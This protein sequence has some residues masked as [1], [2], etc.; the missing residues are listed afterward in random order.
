MKVLIVSQYFW[1][2]EFR[3]NDLSVEL[4]NLGHEVTVLTG[5]PNYPLGKEFNEFS[6]KPSSFSNYGGVEIVRV[7]I[8]TRGKSSFKL[9]LNYLSYV[10]TASFLAPLKLR[11]KSFDV[12]LVCQL[13][14]VT[15]AL[16]AILL[17]K[18]KGIP[19]AMWSLDLWPDSVRAVGKGGPDF[20]YK[21]LE[22][23]VSYIYKNCDLILGQSEEYLLCISELDKGNSKKVIFPNWAEDVFNS[24]FKNLDIGY[25]KENDSFV[26]LFA[27][28]VGEA[29]DFESIVNA[30]MYLKENKQKVIFSIVGDGSKFTWLKSVI[31]AYELE[32]YFELHGRHPVSEMPK[33]YKSANAALLSLK[34]NKIFKLTVPGKLQSYMMS[35][36]PVLGMIDGAGA[37]LIN[38]SKCGYATNASD[39]VNLAKNIM[40]MIEMSPDEMSQLGQNGYEYAV[41]HFSRSALVNRLSSELEHLK[42]K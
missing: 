11:N 18:L 29:Q 2:E 6:K 28:N 17:K 33:Y 21:L 20:M 4:V 15:V 35:K 12:I 42:F 37:S 40:K 30:A 32:S 39:Y 36:L 7:P 10:L 27:G 31:S 9:A 34:T 22:K 16:P 5:I 23:L 19:L 24:E 3:I 38:D 14:P 25:K 13:S 26:V 8:I 41:N 1:P